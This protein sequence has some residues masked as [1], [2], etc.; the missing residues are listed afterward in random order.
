MTHQTPDRD[1]L[2]NAIAQAVAGANSDTVTLSTADVESLLYY[3]QV[4][5]GWMLQAKRMREG[6]A[7]NARSVQKGMERRNRYNARLREHRAELEAWLDIFV[8]FLAEN[9]L[10]GAFNTSAQAL[11]LELEVER[12]E[13]AA[14]DNEAPVEAVE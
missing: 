7:Q 1:T 9:N 11:G 4:H 13:P 8:R 14:N 12:V 6:Y 2:R 5:Y 10:V 3:E